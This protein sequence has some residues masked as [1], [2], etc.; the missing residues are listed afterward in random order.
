MK[1]GAY[2]NGFTLVECLVALSIV[3]IALAAG[4]RTS[5][6]LIRNAEYQ[7]LG[8]LASLCAENTLVRVRLSNYLPDIGDYTTD[9]T[10]ASDILSVKLKVTATPNPLFRRVEAEV[11]KNGM[12]VLSRSTVVGKY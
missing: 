10:Q 2:A 8:V 9:C 7:T 3:A 11:S 1:H 5:A 6:A 12:I 4:S